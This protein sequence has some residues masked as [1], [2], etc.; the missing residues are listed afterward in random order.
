MSHVWLDILL[1]LGVAVVAGGAIGWERQH[2]GRPAGMRTHMLVSLGAAMAVS[3]AAGDAAAMSRIVQ[4]VVTGIGF[5]C[6]GE[7][8]HHVRNG[9]QHV[10]GLTS[11]ASLWLTAVIGIVA[12]Y[13]RWE[14]VAIGTVMTL[15]ILTVAKRFEPK[16]SAPKRPARPSAPK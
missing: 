16:K 8:L 3:L 2:S 5:V 4:G 1:R 12:A 11:A 13:G 15:L 9:R 7:I 10:K 6:A 14:L